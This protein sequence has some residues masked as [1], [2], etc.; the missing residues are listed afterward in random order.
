[1]RRAALLVAVALVGWTGACKGAPTRQGFAASTSTRPSTTSSSSTTTTSTTAAVA[2]APNGCDA[3]ALTRVAP[4]A[5]RTKYTVDATLD[6]AANQV[7]GTLKAVF[8]P[9]KDT[10]HLVLRLWPNAP[11]PANKGAHEDIADV[12]VDG[13]AVTFHMDN[14]TTADVDTVDKKPLTPGTAI[15]LALSFTLRLPG[16]SDDRLSR[17]GNTVRL[18]SWLPLLAWEPGVGWDVDPPTTSNA[19][20]SLTVA[21]DFDVHFVAPAGLTVLATGVSDGP[22]HWTATA[23][24]DWAASVGSFNLVEGTAA[25]A[26]VTVGVE[27]S[28]SESPTAYLARVIA[29]LTDLS[30]RYGNYAYPTF[31]LALTPN[32]TGGIE[33]PG[34][35]MQGPNTNARTTPHEVSHQWFYSLVGSDQGRDPWLDEGLASWA[36]AQTNHTYASFL[37]KP[38]PA[39]GRDHIGEPMTFWD[40]IHNDYYR[41]VYVQSVQALGAL[42]VS[43]AAV[44][45]ALARYVAANAYRVATPQAVVDALKTVAPNAAA[46]L[47]KYGVKRIS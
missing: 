12:T 3:A 14:P 39:D 6:L 20:A 47:A 31:T 28:M 26:K 27:R 16:V 32:L 19:E 21:S 17:Q 25:G 36:E 23:M 10:D 24:G 13:H 42:G 11:T 40:P 33:Y 43:T 2:P 5:D 41:S 46:V 45:C 29:A 18:G 15:T 44:D 4:R 35:V 9:D 34:H 37:A 7:T 8:T 1:M 38:I 22:W 30:H